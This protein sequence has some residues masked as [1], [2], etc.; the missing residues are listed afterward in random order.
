MRFVKEKIL[1]IA[2]SLFEFSRYDRLKGRTGR[3]RQVCD[4]DTRG[5]EM[6]NTSICIKTSSKN[7]IIH[8]H[9]VQQQKCCQ[10][11]VSRR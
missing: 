1:G 5:C 10:E 3:Y 9:L 6:S 4:C 11:R 7:V 2:P 8:F